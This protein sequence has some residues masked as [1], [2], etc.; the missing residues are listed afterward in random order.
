[1]SRLKQYAKSYFKSCF[2]EKAFSQSDFKSLSNGNSWNDIFLSFLESDLQ[3]GTQ[4]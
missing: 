3:N 1:M 2:Q 4:Q